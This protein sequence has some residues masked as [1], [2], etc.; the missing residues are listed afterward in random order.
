LDE[1]LAVSE[2]RDERSLEA[3]LYRLKGELHLA[4]KDEQV[5]AETC[6]LTA[7]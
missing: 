1:G 2:E 3:E 6:F 5:A 4:E 7:I